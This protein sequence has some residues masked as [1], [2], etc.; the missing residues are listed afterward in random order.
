MMLPDLSFTH[1]SVSLNGFPNGTSLE[2]QHD[3]FLWHIYCPRPL[4]KSDCCI[5][6]SISPSY[7]CSSSVTSWYKLQQD[8]SVMPYRLNTLVPFPGL[9]CMV[10]ILG[11]I[12]PPT[13][14]TLSLLLSDSRVS[15][16]GWVADRV[17]SNVGVHSWKGGIRS[18]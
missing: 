16:S 10:L 11:N 15:D 3:M 9:L 1:T 14:N 12:S 5:R 6:F 2:Q 4:L 8:T 17:L 18:S 13:A 7:L